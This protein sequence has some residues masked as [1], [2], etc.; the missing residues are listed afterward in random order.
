MSVQKRLGG[1][2]SESPTLNRRRARQF[3]TRGSPS[4]GKK[5]HGVCFANYLLDSYLAHIAQTGCKRPSETASADTGDSHPF[6]IRQWLGNKELETICCSK[7]SR[8]GSF[9]LRNQIEKASLKLPCIVVELPGVRV[10]ANYKYLAPG[11]FP[12]GHIL[13]QFTQNNLGISTQG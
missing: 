6:G 1:R 5:R 10:Q 13:V 12:A 7:R 11:S 9:A 3:R 8:A 2:E 4:K